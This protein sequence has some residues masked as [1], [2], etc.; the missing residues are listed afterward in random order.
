MK[1][2]FDKTRLA[3]ALTAAGLVTVLGV[4]FMKT[5][6]VDFDTHNEIIAT[7]RDLKQVDAEW[8][9]DVLRAKTGLSS[10]YDRV[11]SPLPLIAALEEALSDKSTRFWQGPH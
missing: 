11:A 5:R 10:N 6:A 1:I 3:Y 2:K 4:L 7:M 8:N 9:V